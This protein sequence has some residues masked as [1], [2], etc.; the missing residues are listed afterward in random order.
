MPFL[1]GVKGVLIPVLKT[2]IVVPVAFRAVHQQILEK[3]K[4]SREREVVSFQAVECVQ[5]R[6]MKL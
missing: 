4:Q 3:P 1:V 5:R 2:I 6:I